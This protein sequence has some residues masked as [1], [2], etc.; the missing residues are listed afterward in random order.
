MNIGKRRPD[1]SERMKG[2][3]IRI[4]M[5]P[6]NKIHSVNEVFFKEIDTEEK[7]YWLGYIM[8]D[9]CVHVGDGYRFSMTSIDKKH[10]ELFV[11]TVA[12]TGEAVR[13]KSDNKNPIYTVNIS[14]KRFVCSLIRQGVIPRKTF[15]LTYPHGIKKDLERHFVRGYLDGDGYITLS[16]GHIYAAIAGNFHFTKEL[17]LRMY[18]RC[19][20]KKSSF[21]EHSSKSLWLFRRSGVDAM[22]FC[23]YIYSGATVYLERKHAKYISYK[24]GANVAGAI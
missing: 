3:K 2:N 24:G 8:A 4:D 14:N 7:A 19:K 17:A 5:P 23:D 10:L 18:K 16:G 13:V 21:Y 12:Y 22:K 20:L 9:G 6:G 15:L 11:K 1:V